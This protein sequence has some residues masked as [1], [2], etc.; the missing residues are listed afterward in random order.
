MHEANYVHRCFV[1]RQLTRLY[2]DIDLWLDQ[3]EI[4]M[5]YHQTA[6]LL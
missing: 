6:L 5:V 2:A 1:D 3:P 4:Y